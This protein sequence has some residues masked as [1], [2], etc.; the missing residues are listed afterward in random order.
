MLIYIVEK[1]NISDIDGTYLG[2]LVCVTSV[3]LFL[4]HV[5]KPWQVKLLSLMLSHLLM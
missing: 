3:G 2:S 4:F 5:M 1:A